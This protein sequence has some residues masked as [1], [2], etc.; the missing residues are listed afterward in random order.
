MQEPLLNNDWLLIS[1]N[2]GLRD[3]AELP[4]ED[5]VELLGIIDLPI[6]NELADYRSFLPVHETQYGTY[7]DTA[8]CTNFATNNGIEVV[9]ITKYGEE[10]NWSDRFAVKMS[11]TNPDIGNYASVSLSSPILHGLVLE[12]EW[13]WDRGRDIPIEQRYIEWF[14]SDVPALIKEKALKWHDDW[15]YNWG[16][17]KKAKLVSREELKEALKYSIVG[18]SIPNANWKDENGIYHTSKTDYG[19]RVNAIYVHDDGK[20]DL[21]DHYMQIRTVASDYPMGWATYITLNK[22]PMKNDFVKVLKDKNSQAVGFLTNG[23][24]EDGFKNLMKMHGVPYTE[25]SDGSLDWSSIKID[26]EYELK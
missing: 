26:G 21:L 18:V 8:G 7:Y 13:S 6:I 23:I 25:K 12:E 4:Q 22:K 3:E 17:V 11:G 24:N 10:Y 16:W 5:S 2:T 20:V 15:D 14:Y 19:H 1:E 9:G